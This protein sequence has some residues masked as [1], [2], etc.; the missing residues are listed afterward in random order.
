MALNHIKIKMTDNHQEEEEYNTAPI[1]EEEEQQQPNTATPEAPADDE[2]VQGDVNVVVGSSKKKK[3]NSKEYNRE[4][5]HRTKKE[6][7]CQFCGNRYGIISA[8]V[9]HQRRSSK[10]AVQRISGLWGI[11]R[12]P[13][14]TLMQTAAPQSEESLKKIDVLFPITASQAT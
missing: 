4:Y 1:T 10:C 5:Y 11:V 8:L 7:E 13:I 6:V 14:W 3:K 2:V 12:D 9:R